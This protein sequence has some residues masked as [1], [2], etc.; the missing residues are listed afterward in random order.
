MVCIIYH[1][2]ADSINYNQINR[3]P[4]R[5]TNNAAICGVISV[6]LLSRLAFFISLKSFIR[7]AV[8]FNRTCSR[9]CGF[10]SFV[11]CAIFL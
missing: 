9:S 2:A 1:A 6:Y 5:K 3:S 4:D 11:G 8:F 7:R 10:V